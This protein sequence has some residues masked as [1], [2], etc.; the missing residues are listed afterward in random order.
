ML[1]QRAANCLRPRT[2]LQA[3]LYQRQ[4]AV[5]EVGCFMDA[6]R[7]ESSTAD[8]NLPPGQML[9]DRPTVDAEERGQLNERRTTEIL[10]HQFIDL[11]GSEKGLSHLK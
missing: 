6:G 11:V 7:I 2:D 9:R 8:W 4:P 10:S 3:D 5:V 1:G